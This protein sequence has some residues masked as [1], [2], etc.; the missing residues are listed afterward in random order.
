[1]TLET[2]ISILQMQS[3]ASRF[4]VIFEIVDEYGGLHLCTS[5][6]VMNIGWRTAHI[7]ST[8]ELYYSS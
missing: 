1:M 2:T 5:T 6:T 4:L 7:H 3:L 8:C